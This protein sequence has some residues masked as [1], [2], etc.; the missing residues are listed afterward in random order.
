MRKY[1]TKKVIQIEKDVSSARHCLWHDVSGKIAGRWI[2][3]TTPCDSFAI[4]CF[5]ASMSSAMTG[6]YPAR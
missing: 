6:S 2:M 5:A 3:F 1:T 4:S